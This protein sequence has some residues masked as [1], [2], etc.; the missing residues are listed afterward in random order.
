MPSTVPHGGNICGGGGMLRNERPW[1]EGFQNRTL[2]VVRQ[3]IA[4]P[5]KYFPYIAYNLRGVGYLED[6][7]KIRISEIEYRMEQ[8]Y[9]LKANFTGNALIGIRTVKRLWQE[10]EVFLNCIAAFLQEGSWID[11]RVTHWPQMATRT[12]VVHYTV[13][14]GVL[15]YQR[16]DRKER[17]RVSPMTNGVTPSMMPFYQWR[18]WG[19]NPTLLAEA[20]TARAEAKA[21][22]PILYDLQGENLPMFLEQF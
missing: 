2:R 6:P 3:E 7:I 19:G 21:L 12:L 5:R 15:Y 4:V 11:F 16:E 14:R 9:H 18:S 20:S 10:D 8:E 1:R 22:I 17:V 13:D